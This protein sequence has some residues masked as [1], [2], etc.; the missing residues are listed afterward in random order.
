MDVPSLV[1]MVG[2]CVLLVCVG[3]DIGAHAWIVRRAVLIS[4]GRGLDA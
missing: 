2:M 3:D 1:V 4:L